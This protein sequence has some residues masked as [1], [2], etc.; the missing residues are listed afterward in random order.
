[1]MEVRLIEETKPN[2]GLYCILFSLF[3]GVAFDRLFFDKAF[4]ISYFIFITLCIGFF[5]WSIKGDIKFQKSIGWLL[6]IPIALLSLSFAIYTNE[7]FNGLNFLAVPLLM[8][9]SSILI[10][11]P[12]LKWD[13]AIIIVEVLRKGIVNVLSNIGKPFNII[14]VSIRKNSAVKMKESKKQILLGIII[15][16][17]LLGIII[18]LLSSAD[19]VFNYYLN[20]ITEIFQGIDLGVYVSHAVIILIVAFYMFG[21]VWGFKVKNKDLEQGFEFPPVKWEAVTII[22]VLVALNIVYLIFTMIQFSYL[23]GGGNMTLPES[24]TYAEY[25]RRGFFELAAVTFINFVI[26]LSCIKFVK[27]ENKRLAAA[28]NVFLTILIAFTLNMLFSAN[29]KLTLYES[30]YGYTILRVMVHLF[31]LLL[32]ILCLVVVA[33][34]WFRKIPI[35]KCIIVTAIAAYTIVNYL[36]I[37]GFVARKNIERYHETGKIDAQYLTSLSYEAVPYMLEL[38]N[39]DDSNKRMIVEDNLKYRKQALE[40]HNSWSEF[41]FSKNKVRNILKQGN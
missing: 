18:A 39:S 13:K 34:I 16:L 11:N 33:G 25:A 31:M 15:S 12:E 24:F 3:L 14:G 32:F 2:G 4:G 23:Y 7:A 22:T 8:V 29:F 9:V 27:R 1:M 35:M 37:D 41:N 5:L 38:R 40:R 19:M 26:V 17:P 36:N 20:N 28:A 30:T 21:Y 6:L 10:A